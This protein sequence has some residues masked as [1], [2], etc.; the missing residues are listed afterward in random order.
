MQTLKYKIF[1]P[2]SKVQQSWTQDDLLL[3][4]SSTGLQIDQKTIQQ[5]N[6]ELVEMYRDKSKKQAQTQHLYDTLKKRVMTSQVQTAASDSVAQ[7]INSMSSIPRPQ[8]FGDPSFQPHPPTSFHPDGPRGSDRHLQTQHS[9]S[10]S[11][12]SRNAPFEIG[13]AAMPPP[14][15]P[16]V[17]H[18]SRKSSALSGQSLLTMSDGFASSI[19]QHRTHLPATARTT[20]TRSQIP[21]S[22]RAPGTGPCQPMANITN[23]RNSNSRSSSY[24]ITAGMKI[25]RPLRSS[26]SNG[27]RTSD[28]LS[29]IASNCQYSSS[30][31]NHLD[32]A[33]GNEAHVDGFG[34]DKSFSGTIL[35]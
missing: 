27:D 35:Y 4:M 34:N 21:L 22:T 18:H 10:P 30:T 28:R 33:N 23:T 2:R 16:L 19:P 9:R 13:V 32:R 29:G 11:Q 17:G 25:G 14:S 3:L 12:S 31:S 1:R 6:V 7:A 26:L 24:G 15:G 20:A 5:K 8:P